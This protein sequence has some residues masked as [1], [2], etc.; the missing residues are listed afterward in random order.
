MVLVLLL[1]IHKIDNFQ[2]YLNDVLT[3][4]NRYPKANNLTLNFDKTNIM[5]FLTQRTCSYINKRYGNTK[6]EQQLISWIT[7]SQSHQVAKHNECIIP[8]VSSAHFALKTVISL[9]KTQN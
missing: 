1:H 4:S 5:Q 6:T 8:R 7:N 3:V 2:N 9:T